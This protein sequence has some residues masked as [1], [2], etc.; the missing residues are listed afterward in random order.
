V[1]VQFG[2]S[3]EPGRVFGPAVATVVI[4]AGA[5]ATSI[6]FPPLPSARD[7]RVAS[8]TL[9]PDA[10][11]YTGCPVSALVAVQLAGREKSSSSVKP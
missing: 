4:P 6:E 9:L 5:D 3:A 10:S 1:R 8:V 7:D 2:G 11:Y